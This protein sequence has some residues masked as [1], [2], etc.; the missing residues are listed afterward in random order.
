MTTL[1]NYLKGNLI[2]Q[3]QKHVITIEANLDNINIANE[4]FKF[5][6]QQNI[7]NSDR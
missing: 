2:I 6:Y 3:K 4:I 7:K 1:Q 5:S